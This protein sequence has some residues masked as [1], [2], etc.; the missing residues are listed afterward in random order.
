ME[1][2]H[3]YCYPQFAFKPAMSSGNTNVIQF[4][5]FE[6]IMGSFRPTVLHEIHVATFSL[7]CCKSSSSRSL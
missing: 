3:F 1:G 5:K 6:Q 7:L 2:Y 4:K